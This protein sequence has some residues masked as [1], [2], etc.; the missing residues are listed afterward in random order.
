[1]HKKL[2]WVGGGK[3]SN[4]MS[5]GAC[6]LKPKQAMIIIAWSTLP[7]DSGTGLFGGFSKQAMNESGR[8]NVCCLY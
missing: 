7:I 5:G 3:N 4:S 2:S 1:M 6:G 8:E